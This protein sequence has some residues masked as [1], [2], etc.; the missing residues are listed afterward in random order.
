V[1]REEGQALPHQFV[2]ESITLVPED[3]EEGSPVAS[4]LERCKSHVDNALWRGPFR[5]EA[6]LGKVFDVELLTGDHTLFKLGIDLHRIA[7]IDWRQPAE[8]NLGLFNI[9][10]AINMK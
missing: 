9:E 10:P 4:S 6:A 7:R 1:G 5:R 2:A 3:A 8:I